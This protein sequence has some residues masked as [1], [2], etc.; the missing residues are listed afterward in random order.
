[1]KDFLLKFI[2]SFLLAIANANAYLFSFLNNVNL[3]P[4][5]SRHALSIFPSSLIF[6]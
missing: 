4:N 1:M 2:S 5:T 6:P 3:S